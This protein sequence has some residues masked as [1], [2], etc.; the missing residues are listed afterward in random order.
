MVAKTK[1]RQIA[2]ALH[3]LVDLV[4]APALA[5][6][7]SEPRLEVIEA[8]LSK[9][10]VARILDVHPR[11]IDR[12]I[13]DRRLKASGEGRTARIEPSEVERFKRE[14]L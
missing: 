4:I 6:F 5:Q 7:G 12:Y 10:Q 13:K 3:T 11:T 9:S 8:M 2:E 14:E 1:E